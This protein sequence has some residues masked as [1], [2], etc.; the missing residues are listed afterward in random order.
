MLQK[1]SY[2]LNVVGLEILWIQNCP[3]KVF[4]QHPLGAHA[5][6]QNPRTTPSGRKAK[7]HTPL[8]LMFIA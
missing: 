3:C 8:E 1:N 7:T 5:R 4:L 2:N 6:F